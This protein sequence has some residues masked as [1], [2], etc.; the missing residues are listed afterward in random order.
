MQ[1]EDNSEFVAVDPDLLENTGEERVRIS[2]YG[3][4]I[5]PNKKELV[6]RTRRL[7]KE[8]RKVVDIA[9]KY[10]KDIRKA[11][12]KGQRHPHPPHLMVHGAAG[13]GELI[14]TCNE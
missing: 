6:E 2:E 13:T 5:I 7:D 10:A 3:R 1:V 8:Q 12:R 4:I 14:F 9:V 11:R